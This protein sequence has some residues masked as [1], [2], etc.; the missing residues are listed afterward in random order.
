MA[1]SRRLS[2]ALVILT[3]STFVLVGSA[4]AQVADSAWAALQRLDITAARTLFNR[5]LEKF[6]GN[7]SALRGLIL[8]EHFDCRYDEQFAYLRALAGQDKC[9]PYLTAVLEHMYAELKTFAGQDSVAQIILDAFARS[10]DPMTRYYG[11]HA[12]VKNAQEAAAP[13]S[14]QDLVD[15]GRVPGCWI[16]GPFEN[17]SRIAALRLLPFE[18]LPLDT[19]ATTA[20]KGGALV[21][22][23]YLPG[24]PYGDLNL[25]SVIEDMEDAAVLVR[26]AFSVPATQTVNI[27]AGGAFHYRLRVDGAEV[28]ENRIYRNSVQRE[29]V[30]LTLGPGT[31][32]VTM[33]LGFLEMGATIVTLSVVGE[34]FGPIDGLRWH[35]DPVAKYLAPPSA[36]PFHP[37]FDP[38]ARHVEANGAEPDTRYWKSL[39]QIYN[40]YHKEAIRDLEDTDGQAPLSPLEL[41][42]LRTALAAND[43]ETRATECLRRINDH[44]KCARTEWAWIQ[45]NKT[46]HASSIREMEVMSATYPDRFDYDLMTMLLP[47]VNGDVPGF[48][49]KV[50]SVRGKYPRAAGVPTLMAVLY[51]SVLNDNESSLEQFLQGCRMVGNRRDE[52]IYAPTRYAS[53][54]KFDEAIATAR[55]AIE[56][57][58]PSDAFVGS[59]AN[60]CILANRHLEA[61]PLLDS[62]LQQY[63][64]NIDLAVILHQIYN[65]TGN[66]TEARRMLELIYRY[67]PSAVSPYLKLDS[68]RNNAPLDSIFGT[69]DPTS[70][71]DMEPT[72]E[73]LA[74]QG[75]WGLIDRRQ[76]L[77]F[78]TGVA[79][80]D[81]HNAAVLVDEGTVERFQEYYLGF[82]AD[83]SNYTLMT[84]RR[85]RKGQPPMK[86]DHQ[87]E[88]VLFRD[89]KPGDA[90][91]IRYRSW[92]ANSGDLWNEYWD[93]YYVSASIFQR[94]WEYSII[95]NRKDVTFATLPPCPEKK[96]ARHFGFRKTTW[97]GDYAMPVDLE[98][99]G[100]PPSDDIVGKIFV[101]TL[102]NWD[103][104]DRWY[105]SISEAIL[106]DNPR[107]IQRARELVA[108]S[109]TPSEKLRKL[110]ENIVLD[111]PYQTIFFD[112]HA[113][114]PHTPDEVLVN[115]WGDCKDKSHLLIGMLREVGIPAWAVL[116]MTRGN[117]TQLPLPYFGF[118]HLIVGAVIDGDTVY[119]DPSST[120][121]APEHS[122]SDWVSGQPCLNV[123][124]SGKSALQRLPQ[125]DTDDTYMSWSLTLAA[126]EDGRYDF[127]ISR[128]WDKLSAGLMREDYRDVTVQ[129]ACKDKEAYFADLWG[130]SL[131][132]DSLSF[133]PVRSVAR[134]YHDEW[135]G[136]MAL[137]NQVLGKAVVVN[138]PRLSRFEKSILPMLEGHTPRTQPVDL[139]EFYGRY[140][141]TVTFTPPSGYGPPQVLDPVDVTDSL[142]S[143]KYDSHWD[144]TTR[145]LRLSY[146]ITI[147]DGHVPVDR[148]R[149][150]VERVIEVF[151]SPLLFTEQRTSDR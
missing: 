117:G 58:G 51:Q 71:W 100:M 5:H 76:V 74:S 56:L 129:Q 93:S 98:P 30:S 60:V 105:H 106:D 9:D 138:L 120:P 36:Q 89:L 44:A 128:E 85:L 63:P 101:S 1:R 130:V 22:W 122:L 29:G 55:E 37:L 97:Q 38:L 62:M 21:E 136:T 42:A 47:L 61:V 41:W 142:M 28:Y 53:V 148:F 111:I 145:Q 99:V 20:G 141:S 84:A 13:V 67:K 80:V 83:E 78:G 143:M 43:E 110:Y 59:F 8:T 94:H 126:R 87:G 23:R 134:Q 15:L 102:D 49:A 54:R 92:V 10:S 86:G 118:D 123:G 24:G 115:R 135:S 14:E 46:D 11:R 48:L 57:F 104:L 112:Y 114:I 81:N 108:A 64:S 113:S 124:G 147:Q 73:Q 16:A 27:L 17:Q 131:T 77:L 32:E 133:D 69:V 79:C 39:L 140:L 144:E 52:L 119:V 82:T 121:Y 139:R 109:D 75:S 34:D 31:H 40:G 12:S 107:A 151:E 146:D 26:F 25:S 149:S 4:G 45:A 7:S 6:P 132:I 65:A 72:P 91:E 66:H 2:R 103:Q 35:H 3:L 90:I 125:P 18:D 88:S 95:T 127:S 137:A 19:M 70:Y 50:E 33:A 116:V 96:E 68:L 150:F